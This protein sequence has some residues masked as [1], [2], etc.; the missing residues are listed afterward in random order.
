MSEAALAAV[1]ATL[2][3]LFGDYVEYSIQYRDGF[4]GGFLSFVKYALRQ[5][6]EQPAEGPS[7]L[8]G[9]AST[10]NTPFICCPV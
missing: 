4:F 2:I 6:V 5:S 9:S 10:L 1:L 8:R 3:L 7:V